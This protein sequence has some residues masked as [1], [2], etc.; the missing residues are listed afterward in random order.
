MT[1]YWSMSP[2]FLPRGIQYFIRNLRNWI[3]SYVHFL[4]SASS[5]DCSVELYG[6]Q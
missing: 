2:H 6:G 1:D 3:A 5:R 4:R